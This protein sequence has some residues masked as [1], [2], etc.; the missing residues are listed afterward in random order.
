MY[1]LRRDENGANVIDYSHDK[2]VGYA[3]MVR[4]LDLRESVIISFGILM[5]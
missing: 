4:R 2:V 5:A 1:S 3:A